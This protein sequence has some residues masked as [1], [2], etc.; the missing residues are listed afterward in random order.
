[1]HL[2]LRYS[3]ESFAILKMELLLLSNLRNSCKINQ[4]V[5][6]DLKEKELAELLYQKIL[7]LDKTTIEQKI[8]KLKKE[9]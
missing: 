1:M 8:W 5:F 6:K 4:L 9:L 7:G 2:R 3:K